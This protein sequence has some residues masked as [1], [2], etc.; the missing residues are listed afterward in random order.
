MT[1]WRGLALFQIPV[2]IVGLLFLFLGFP[3]IDWKQKETQA[4]TYARGA[5]TCDNAERVKDSACNLTVSAPVLADPPVVIATNT[6]AADECDTATTV[7]GGRCNA[8]ATPITLEL[9]VARLVG[10]GVIAG[11]FWIL[12]WLWVINR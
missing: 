9:I 6:V 2:V 5:S 7:D 11:V 10:F 1:L 4:I 3:E 12:F 8:H